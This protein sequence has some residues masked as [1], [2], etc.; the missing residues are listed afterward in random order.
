MGFNVIIA[1]TVKDIAK[2]ISYSTNATINVTIITTT[3]SI[4]LITIKVSYV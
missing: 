1:G 3:T 2:V 4:I